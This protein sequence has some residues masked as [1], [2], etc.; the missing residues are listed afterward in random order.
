MK[1]IEK[2]CPNCGAS[3][4]FDKDDTEVT[5]EYC[6]RHFTVQR[7]ISDKKNSSKTDLED[8]DFEL[9]EEVFNRFDKM[10][11][12]M[13]RTPRIVSG[14]IIF[15]A[16]FVIVFIVGIFN[17]F[18]STENDTSTSV[19]KVETR[20]VTEISQIDDKSLEMF[21]KESL[22]K[23]NSRGKSYYGDYSEWTY[24]GMYLLNSKSNKDNILFDIFKITVTY[25]GKEYELYGAV[26]YDHLKLSDDDKVLNDFSGVADVPM[27]FI[28]GSVFLL[29]Y[30]GNE[31]LYFKSI[32]SLRDQYNIQ[33]T[34]GLYIED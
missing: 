20:Y 22:N 31:S 13:F 19:N 6:N 34:E 5:C 10:T 26:G 23:L 28:K 30:D 8:I 1:L 27:L 32:R 4:K 11:S 25:D 21:H 29:G 33:A 7:D 2:K 17:T 18:K 3:L 14:I 15:I 9:I 24:V 12:S 16:I